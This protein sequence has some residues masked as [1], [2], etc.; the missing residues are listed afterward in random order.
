MLSNELVARPLS[1]ANRT[2][3]IAPPSNPVELPLGLEI[4]N[5][6]G[7]CWRIDAPVEELWPEQERWLAALAKRVP[8]SPQSAEETHEEILALR[9]A[10]PDGVV[11]LD[12]EVSGAGDSPVFLAGALHTHKKQPIVTQL[13]AR[14]AEEEAALLVALDE[15]LVGKACLLTFNGK[16]CDWPL[17]QERRIALKLGREPWSRKMVH[18][19]LLHH[20]RRRWKTRLPNCKLQTLEQYVCGRQRGADASLASAAEVYRHFLE[21]GATA[22]LRSVLH[23]HSMDIITLWQ[24]GLWMAHA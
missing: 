24:L 22:A 8:A 3:T 14:T 20:A 6:R 5:R 21:T 15:I 16:S 7:V 11:L 1:A 17:V 4:E 10:L 9:A 23:H 12:L 13:V 19:D 2:V 18:C